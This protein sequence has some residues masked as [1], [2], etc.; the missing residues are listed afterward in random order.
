[1]PRR[2]N[3]SLLAWLITVLLALIGCA[4]TIQQPSSEPSAS[5][6]AWGVPY[7]AELHA[8]CDE[9][10]ARV[11]KVVSK[12]NDPKLAPMLDSQKRLWS[13]W[14]DFPDRWRLC[15]YWAQMSCEGTP[16]EVEPN[17][18]VCQLSE[19]L[20][21]LMKRFEAASQ[22]ANAQLQENLR[23]INTQ[24]GNLQSQPV[25]EPPPVTYEPPIWQ[26]P[27]VQSPP[28]QNNYYIRAPQPA[29]APTIVPGLNIRVPKP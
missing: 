5:E 14:Q 1:M 10:M 8:M 17:P 6:P 15:K 9:W 7:D 23:N 4:P 27:V 22:E 18:A 3:R 24:I 2:L 16:K 20:D 28:V 25:Y 12:V 13:T 19:K 26:P 11:F 29:A 21:D